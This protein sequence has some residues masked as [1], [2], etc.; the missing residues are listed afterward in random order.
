MLETGEVV[1]HELWLTSN[2]QRLF[3]DCY[4]EPAR[5]A[6]GNIIGVGIAAVNLTEQ[7]R[8][9][10]QIFETNQRL[11]ALMQA[12]PVGVALVDAQGGNIAANPAYEQVWSGPRP[13][14]RSVHDYAA[15]QAWWAETGEPLKPEDWASARAIQHGE[16]VVGQLLRIR[17]F[18]G[19]E[20]V[21]LNSAAP[22]RDAGGRIT[23]S[24]VAIQ[25][26]TAWQESERRLAVAVSGARIGLFEWNVATGELLW[27]PQHARLFGLD[28]TT[29]NGTTPTTATTKT[30]VS[31]PHTYADW[32]SRVHPEDFPRVE[33]E[34]RRCLAERAPLE[35][36]YRIV[37]PDGSLHWIGTRAVLETDGEGEPRRMLGVVIDVTERKD[38]EEHVRASLAE[39]EVLLKEIHHR[40][41]NNMQVICSLMDIQSNALADPGMREHF[42]EVRDRVRSMALVHEKLYQSET[43]ASIEFAD[44][45]RSLLESL[46]KAHRNPET[47]VGLELDLQPVLLSIETAVPCGLILNELITNAFKHAFRDRTKGKV[48][49]ELRTNP[50]GRVCLRV[51]DDGPGLPAGMDWRQS[52]SLGLRL[53]HLLAGQL[54]ATL[55][56][57]PGG[58]AD[59]LITFEPSQPKPAEEEN[60]A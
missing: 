21:V 40:V 28:T 31:Q 35:V 9:E 42:R 7:K 38:A 56:V 37:W 16:A 24:A 3:L 26:V 10:A 52:R 49:I 39:K 23:G 34:L 46:A 29:S 43:L 15:Y 54:D 48:S 51:S 41:K 11:E 36:D 2:G 25:D 45:T 19:S 13:P 12:I 6:S 47:L 58:G 17:R 57:R 4:Y 1:R 20:A 18:D 30:T 53:I 55:E 32:A 44:Y 8:A 27:N 50:D 5:D 22:I 14:V 33:A 59:F 60:H